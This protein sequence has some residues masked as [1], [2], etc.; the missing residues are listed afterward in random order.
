MAFSRI[1]AVAVNEPV[2][3][4]KIAATANVTAVP[5][6]STSYNCNY[7]IDQS[8]EVAYFDAPEDT[9][10]TTSDYV[11]L[12]TQGNNSFMTGANF[13]ASYT[14][15]ESD[16]GALVNLTDNTGGTGTDTL[17]A[18]TITT[19]ADLAAVGVQLGVI[20]NCISSLSDKVN[21]IID[22]E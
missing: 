8:S 11:V 2:T 5:R 15:F 12:S 3:F 18:I 22:A 7:K 6:N 1:K 21:E 20:R 19:P 9:T 17:A 14:A 10:F 16:L 13:D 4:V